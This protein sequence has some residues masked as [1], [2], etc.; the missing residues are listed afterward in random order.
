NEQRRRDEPAPVQMAA[1]N[2]PELMGDDEIERV[3]IVATGFDQLGIQDDK[4]PPSEPGGESVE[5]AAGLL[6]VDVGNA[7]HTDPLRDIHDSI[8]QL[9]HLLRAKPD[10]AAANVTNQNHVR[11]KDK[12]ADEESI[13]QTDNGHDEH[14]PQG[15]RDDHQHDTQGDF[16]GGG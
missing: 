7:L 16:G 4:S 3:E 9:G 11:E 15:E 8:V 13:D 14:D 2:M 5:D 6:E 12:Q 1:M 10:R